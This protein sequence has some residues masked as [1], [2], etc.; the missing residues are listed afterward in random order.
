MALAGRA[1]LNISKVF[2]YAHFGA[3]VNIQYRFF[4]YRPDFV[5]IERRKCVETCLWAMPYH[6]HPGDDSRWT[7]RGNFTG[8]PGFRPLEC[9]HELRDNPSGPV[10]SG[11]APP[12]LYEWLATEWQGRRGKTAI[13]KTHLGYTLSASPITASSLRGGENSGRRNCV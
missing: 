12:S 5:P 6:G 2:I 3:T 13:P 10:S 8:K 11:R 1:A 9:W 4:I 7:E